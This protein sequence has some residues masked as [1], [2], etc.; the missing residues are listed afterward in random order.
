MEIFDQIV[1]IFEQVTHELNDAIEESY[2]QAAEIILRYSDE[3][4]KALH[5]VVGELKQ[6]IEG[7]GNEM[8]GLWFEGVMIKI[9]D[10]QST[11]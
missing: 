7:V 9:M 1:D 5:L 10:I 2:E 3:T 6:R 8:L 4:D 11:I